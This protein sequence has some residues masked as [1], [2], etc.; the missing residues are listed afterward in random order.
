MARTQ[1]RPLISD[2]AQAAAVSAATVSLILNGRRSGN[3]RI[4]PETRERVLRVVA[5][6]G[7]VPNQTARSLRRRKTERIRLYVARLG[8]PYYDLLAQ[9]LQQRAADHG[10]T[11]HIRR[12][13]EEKLD[14]N[15]GQSIRPV[16]GL[17]SGPC[18]G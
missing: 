6:L 7:Y 3:D 9:S 11:P 8:V 1:R 12:I 10:Y 4:G 18:L 17:S 14:E 5:E 13:G 16:A 15:H 2:V